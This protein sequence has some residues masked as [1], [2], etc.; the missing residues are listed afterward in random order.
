MSSI[1]EIIDNLASIKINTASESPLVYSINNATHSIRGAPARIIFP[2]QI[3]ESEGQ[4]YQRITLGSSG[5][6]SVT[7]IIA[8]LLLYKSVKRGTTLHNSLSEL[9]DYTVNYTIKIRPQMSL[10][11]NAT[12]ESI[13]YEWNR[14]NY[15]ETSESEYYGCLMTLTVKEIIQ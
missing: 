14:Y 11:N 15:P 12:I 5:A 4:S 13:N 3:L 7:W 8:D 6:I 10:S 2:M 9:I 1:R